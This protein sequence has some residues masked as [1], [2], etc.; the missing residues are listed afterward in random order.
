MRDAVQYLGSRYARLRLITIGTRSHGEVIRTTPGKWGTR[1]VPVYFG[2]E[3]L[4]SRA[5][6]QQLVLVRSHAWNAED[7]QIT[8][9]DIGNL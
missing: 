9:E 8:L 4:V 5:S 6:R 7:I 2:I 3:P 1:Q